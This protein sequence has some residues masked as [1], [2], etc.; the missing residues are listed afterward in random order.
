MQN[1]T[2][3]VGRLGL[4]LIFIL[5]GIGKITAY[6]ATAK[7][8]VAQGMPPGLLPLVILVE[9]GGGLSVLCGLF[10]RWSAVA[11]FVYSILTAVVF[12]N[13]LAEHEQWINF[14]KNLAIAGGFLVLA[15]H[16][17]GL[18]SLDGW[19]RRRKQKQKI[20]F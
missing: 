14:M 18:L 8:L 15:V 5:S 12:H 16:G 1:F 9:L 4:S 20:F 2:L 19:R 11:L 10:T 13:H 6:H 17:P 3:L 7:V